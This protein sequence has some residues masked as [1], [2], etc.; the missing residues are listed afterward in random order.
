MAGYAGEPGHDGANLV[1]QPRQVVEP[2]HVRPVRE[3][4]PVRHRPI[5]VLVNL[6]EEGI[7]AYR[8]RGPRQSL[9]VLAL[10]S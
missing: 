7:H 8:H 3:R 6:H 10:A 2:Q 9:H 1:E 5:R 4:A